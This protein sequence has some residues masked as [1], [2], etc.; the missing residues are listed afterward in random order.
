MAVL[1]MHQHESAVVKTCL[2]ELCAPLSAYCPE[3]FSRA[4]L[5]PT[6]DMLIR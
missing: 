5:A 6:L 3:A 4:Y 2:I 1:S